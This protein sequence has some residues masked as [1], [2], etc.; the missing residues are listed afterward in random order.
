M[1][2]LNATK[3]AGESTARTSSV[4]ILRINHKLFG[5]CRRSWFNTAAALAAL[6]KKLE[7]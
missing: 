2:F 4:Q 3:A 1:F 7:N 6:H 5:Q